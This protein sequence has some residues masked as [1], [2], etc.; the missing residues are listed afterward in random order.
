MSQQDISGGLKTDPIVLDYSSLPPQGDTF[1]E[2]A[3][4][5]AQSKLVQRAGLPG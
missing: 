1:S 3:R 5:S 4:R 2:R